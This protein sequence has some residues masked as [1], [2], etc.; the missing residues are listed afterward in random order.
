MGLGS[1]RLQVSNKD[2]CERCLLLRAKEPPPRVGLASAGSVIH[3]TGTVKLLGHT[4]CS[5]L[6]SIDSFCSLVSA[7]TKK[8]LQL[9]FQGCVLRVSHLTLTLTPAR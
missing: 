1:H 8:Y 2:R 9:L 4:A 3:S 6:G 7:V 5:W